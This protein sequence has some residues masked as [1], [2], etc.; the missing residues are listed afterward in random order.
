MPLVDRPDT[1]NAEKE[2]ASQVHI[3]LYDPPRDG[4]TPLDGAGIPQTSAVVLRD[5]EAK[6][7]QGFTR[8]V[9]GIEG[10]WPV[11]GDEPVRPQDM[12]YMGRIAAGVERTVVREKFTRTRVVKK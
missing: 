9:V 11:L 8:A 3:R 7:A 1:A 2:W 6:I 5:R 4:R 10:D 12:T